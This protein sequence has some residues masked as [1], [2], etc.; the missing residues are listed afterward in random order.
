MTTICFEVPGAPVGKE[1]I[2]VNTKTKQAY[3]GDKTR[4][5]FQ[6]IQLIARNHMQLKKLKKLEGPI[7]FRLDII[8]KEKLH[9]KYIAPTQK[10]DSSNI[11]K[12]VE[13]A[14]SKIC[15]KDD[16]DIVVHTIYKW[17]GTREGIVITVKNIN[18]IG[19]NFHYKN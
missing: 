19:K 7:D 8:L 11:L 18:C 12:T 15:Y 13:D 9:T 16:K 14:L 1:E 3:K 4:W 2:R 10:P 17:F 6:Q 5:Y